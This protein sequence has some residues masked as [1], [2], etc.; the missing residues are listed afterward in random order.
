MCINMTPTILLTAQFVISFFKL[1]CE[2]KL[3]F[4]VDVN[5]M[6]YLFAMLHNNTIL[7]INLV[8]EK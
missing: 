1:S 6:L 8:E 5:S 2:E 4:F 7:I 3:S